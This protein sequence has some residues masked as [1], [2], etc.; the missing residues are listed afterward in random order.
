M[1]TKAETD[2]ADRVVMITGASRGIGRACA[3]ALAAP[4]TFL[5]LGYRSRR[6]EAASVLEA[7]RELGADGTL[8]AADVAEPDAVKGIFDQLLARCGRLDV[9]VA[10]AGL[11]DDDLAMRLGDDKWQAVLDANL[12]GAFY[13]V[14]AA[15]RPMLRQRA[16]RIVT[17]GSVVGLR[18]NPGQANYAAAK[19]GLVGMSK[20]V[21]REVASRNIT[22]NVV[23]PGFIETEMT[24]AMS[25]A[26]RGAMLGAVPLGRP[27]RAEEVAALV[28]FICG[29]EAGYITGQ[30]FIIDGGLSM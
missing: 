15:L 7:A 9:L 14:R 5:G 3:L 30:V 13:C 23:A 8:L 10:N 4:G 11:T 12:T 26:A 29:P 18:G 17:V 24:G 2:P 20:S 19:A 28:E 1:T 21:A 16:G 25:P 22:V 27:G 6:D